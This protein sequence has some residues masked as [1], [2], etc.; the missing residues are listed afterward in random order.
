MTTQN[1]ISINAP[2]AGSDMN[3]RSAAILSMPIR[4]PAKL[5]AD[6]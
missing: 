4:R 5:G 2:Q 3:L 1:P 6:F